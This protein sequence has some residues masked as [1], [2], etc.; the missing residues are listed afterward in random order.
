MCNDKI[1]QIWKHIKN[2][3]IYNIKIEKNYIIIS[4]NIIWKIDNNLL[5]GQILYNN[6]KQLKIQKLPTK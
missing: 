5:N 2:N 4:A 3:T 6:N 1:L